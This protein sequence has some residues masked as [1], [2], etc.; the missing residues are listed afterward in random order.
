MHIHIF[1]VSDGSWIYSG[2]KIPSNLATDEYV[3]G[4]L[5]Q[6]EEWDQ[7]YEYTCVNGVAVKG[8]AIEFVDPPED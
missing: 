8:D 5:P 6:G 1:K 2:T 3:Q 7:N 4:F